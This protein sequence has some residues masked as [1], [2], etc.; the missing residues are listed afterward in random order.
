MDQYLAETVFGT[1]Q[2]ESD[3]AFAM[4]ILSDIEQRAHR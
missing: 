2:E 1:R 3:A 4:A